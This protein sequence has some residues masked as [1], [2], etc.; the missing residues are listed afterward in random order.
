MVKQSNRK[1]P[2]P[3]HQR[4]KEVLREN[5]KI[6]RGLM[7]VLKVFSCE[8]QHGLWNGKPGGITDISEDTLE[9]GRQEL[10]T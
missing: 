3:F 9:D 6:Q 1:F 2:F 7:V 4:E 10:E 5:G 8:G